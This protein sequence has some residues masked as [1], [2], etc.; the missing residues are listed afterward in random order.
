M[1]TFI[2]LIFESILNKR[3][4]KYESKCDLLS[5]KASKLEQLIS[6]NE[7]LIDYHNKVI[8]I[9]TTK[10]SYSSD[11]IYNN[12]YNFADAIAS[13]GWFIK[14]GDYIKD[15]KNP[16]LKS[17]LKKT[18]NKIAYYKRKSNLIRTKLF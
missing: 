4:L 14:E 15:K 5:V 10:M 16:K 6:E 8:R 11:K 7:N 13:A 18:K 12:E 1:N 9:G 17:Q 2:K 3:L